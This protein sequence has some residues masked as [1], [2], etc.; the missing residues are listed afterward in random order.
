MNSHTAAVTDVVVGLILLTGIEPSPMHPGVSGYTNDIQKLVCFTYPNVTFTC[1]SLHKMHNKFLHC[2]WLSLYLISYCWQEQTRHAP[3]V[4]PTARYYISVAIYLKMQQ[5]SLQ[6]V[7]NKLSHSNISVSFF[8]YLLINR[9]RQHQH[10]PACT[11]MPQELINQYSNP[12]ILILLYHHLYINS[13]YKLLMI[14]WYCRQ[15]YINLLYDAWVDP[16]VSDTPLTTTI[17]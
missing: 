5:K 17:G 4:D 3:G 13:C 1:N 7:H 8:S 14:V 12:P 11:S 2:C 16:P 10:A 9:N 6:A 15:E